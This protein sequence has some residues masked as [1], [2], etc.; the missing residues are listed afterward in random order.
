MPP[1]PALAPSAKPVE[2]APPPP[3]SAPAAETVS[4]PPPEPSN[5]RDIR[6]A[7]GRRY[8]PRV[9]RA[10]DRTP[11]GARPERL[12]EGA[13]GTEAPGEPVPQEI[14]EAVPQEI[15]EAAAE[16]VPLEIK[17]AAGDYETVAM[18]SGQG[19]K[20]TPVK[21]AA[22]ARPGPAG[23]EPRRLPAMVTEPT[24]PRA[25]GAA[26]GQPSAAGAGAPEAAAAGG[27]RS[28][29]GGAGEPQAARPRP[30]LTEPAA[31]RL[32]STVGNKPGGLIGGETAPP[33]ARS[34]GANQPT[35]PLIVDLQSGPMVGLLPSHPGFGH[36]AFL[37]QLVESIPGAR[38]IAIEGGDFLLGFPRQRPGLFGEPVTTRPGVHPVNAGDLSMARQ[39]AQS[40]PQ[41]P[42][43]SAAEVGQALEQYTKGQL[44]G[45]PFALR[46]WQIDPTVPFPRSGPVTVLTGPHG[47]PQAWFPAVGGEGRLV[48][49]NQSDVVALQP[50][51]HPELHGLVDQVYWRRPFAL[52]RATP[53]VV[54]QLGDELNQL[55]KPGGFAEFRVLEP[56]DLAVVHDLTSRIAGPRTVEVPGEA[57]EHYLGRGGT[58]PPNLTDEQWQLIQNAAPDV[59]RQQGA[60]GRGAFAGIIRIFKGL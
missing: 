37:P 15:P 17:R 34:P 38:G 20:P 30:E 50:T 5:I 33:G 52:A 35:G 12:R 16:P 23:G 53:D 60:L 46:P 13:P 54:A 19:P 27:P 32:A 59:Q 26:A 48:P 11:R 8:D 49:L 36:P 43:Y 2:T 41:W 42:P 24:A 39:L 14:P 51:T 55:L 44:G 31:P 29:P 3:E 7:R 1:E 58:R 22:L 6:S 28:T 40:T 10:L 25:P 45:A 21:P 57:I 56:E 18:A 4:Q 47:E 9:R